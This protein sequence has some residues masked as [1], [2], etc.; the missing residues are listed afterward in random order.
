MSELPDR[1]GWVGEDDRD[2]M[3]NAINN[4]RLWSSSTCCGS[5]GTNPLAQ[6]IHATEAEGVRLDVVQMTEDPVQR[7]RK[8]STKLYAATA[9]PIGQDL[10]LRQTNHSADRAIALVWRRHRWHAGDVPV[11]GLDGHQAVTEVLLK[12]RVE[13]GGITSI[14]RVRQ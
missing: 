4:P 5:E 10:G 3:A 11:H 2:E 7:Q 12:R 8:L 14:Q 9:K 13:G 6:V 1:I